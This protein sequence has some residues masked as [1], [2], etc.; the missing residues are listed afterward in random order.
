MGEGREGRRDGV[1]G[2]GG[3]CGPPR[4]MV[5]DLSYWRAHP[6]DF[7]VE[8]VLETAGASYSLQPLGVALVASHPIFLLNHLVGGLASMSGEPP[9]CLVYMLGFLP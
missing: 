5:R 7:V 4:L 8:T 6:W 9:F 1:D 2:G 3:R